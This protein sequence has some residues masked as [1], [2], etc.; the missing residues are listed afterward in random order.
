M[1]TKALINFTRLKDDELLVLTRTI[2]HAMTDNLH[3]TAPIPPLA[4]IQMLLDYFSQKLEISR[5]RGSP[6]DTALKNE[7]RIPLMED[8]QKLSYYVNAI[9][10]GKLSTLL[11]SGFPINAPSGSSLVPLRIDNL[12]LRDGRQSGQLRIDFAKQKGIRIYEYSYRLANANASWSDRY[13]TT[14]SQSNIIAPLEVGL[15]YEVRVRAVNTQGPGD[16]SNI[17]KILVR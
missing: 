3:F 12:K 10:Q 7:S 15:E 14:S 13:S 1:A 17:S 5:K 2:L 6:E 9:S 8:V 16:W 4:D 11:S